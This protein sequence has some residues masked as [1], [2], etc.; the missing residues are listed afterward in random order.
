[1]T[2]LRD[3]KTGVSTGEAKCDGTQT[4]ECQE[5]APPPGEWMKQHPGR[6]W[7]GWNAKEIGWH[8]GGGT[9]YCPKHHPLKQ[10]PI[11]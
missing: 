10:N 11:P 5:M 4:E 8:C 2:F 6:T 1:M 9:H 3:P 7:P